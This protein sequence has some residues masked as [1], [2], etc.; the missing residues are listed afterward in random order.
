MY[1]HF[2]CDNI[3]KVSDM[4]EDGIKQRKC[5]ETADNTLNELKRFQELLYNNFYKHEHY[6]EM[7]PRSNH[8]G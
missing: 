3:K 4:A 7:L 2:K 5:V 6:K 1:S 8:S